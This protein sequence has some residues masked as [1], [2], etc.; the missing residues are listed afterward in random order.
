MA[1]EGHASQ[2]V[3]AIGRAIIE[4][5]TQVVNL[6]KK[7]AYITKAMKEFPCFDNISL[8]PT[9]YLGQVQML[10]NYFEAKECLGEESFMVA[11]RKLQGVGLYWFRC[12]KRGRPLQDKPRI[13]TWSW[14][15]SY[16]DVR[17]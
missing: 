5:Q 12:P 13:K 2:Q 3:H 10:K 7:I 1:N 15:K 6:S 14:L 11:T 8:D 16:I 9:I 17:F 4:L